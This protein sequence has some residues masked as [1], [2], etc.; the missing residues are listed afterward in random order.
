M[1]CAEIVTIFKVLRFFLALVLWC[2]ACIYIMI[3]HTITNI[4]SVINARLS[5]QRFRPCYGKGQSPRRCQWYLPMYTYVSY[6]L[7]LSL[8]LLFWFLPI[9]SQGNLTLNLHDLHVC[10][11]WAI[12]E[13]ASMSLFSCQGQTLSKLSS[14]FI[15]NWRVVLCFNTRS[16]AITKYEVITM[17]IR[18]FRPTFMTLAAGSF[19]RDVCFK[20]WQVHTRHILAL[21]FSYIYE[22]LHTNK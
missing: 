10:W 14:M 7:L 6:K 12:D 19:A 13:F 2:C 22:I 8:R 3:W 18:V 11:F 9:N 5:R 1:S 21:L 4:Q 16:G 17:R 15:T 20:L